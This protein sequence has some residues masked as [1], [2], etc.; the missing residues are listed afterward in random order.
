MQR[1][2]A[3]HHVEID[4]ASHRSQS[5]Q[6]PRAS[7]KAIGKGQPPYNR[8]R[9]PPGARKYLRP[10]DRKASGLTGHQKPKDAAPLGKI[11]SLQTDGTYVKRAALFREP[12]CWV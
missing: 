5:Q 8:Q 6:D 3:S 2:R 12:T 11:G 10:P 1:A 7:H 4:N 9:Q